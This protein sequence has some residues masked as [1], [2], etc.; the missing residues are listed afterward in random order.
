ML[1]KFIINSQNRKN[2]K[3]NACELGV[4]LKMRKCLDKE[5]LKLRMFEIKGL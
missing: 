4:A 1:L 2:E 5:K 3:L